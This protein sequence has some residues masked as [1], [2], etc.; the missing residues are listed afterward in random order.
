MTIYSPSRAASLQPQ[1]LSALADGEWLNTAAICAKLHRTSDCGIARYALK[2]LAMTGE[3][4]RK[5]IP[6]P[7]SRTGVTYLY[8]RNPE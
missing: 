8:R 7:Q 3:I 1:V 4:E 6:L 2:R 5:A